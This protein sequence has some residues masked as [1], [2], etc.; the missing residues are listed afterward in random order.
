MPAVQGK[1][2]GSGSGSGS[3]AQDHAGGGGAQGHAEGGGGGRSSAEGRMLEGLLRESLGVVN[4]QVTLLSREE[5][6]HLL[7]NFD[8]GKVES[9]QKRKG[10]YERLLRALKEEAEGDDGEGGG[11]IINAELKSRIM[12]QV[13]SFSHASRGLRVPGGVL[14][15]AKQASE[16][17]SSSSSSLSSSLS[18]REFL[19]GRKKRLRNMVAD[20]REA[21][22]AFLAGGGENQ[23]VEAEGSAEGQEKGKEGGTSY[24]GSSHP[25][26][27]MS[28]PIE[29]QREAYV[30]LKGL[31]LLELQKK[32]RQDVLMEKRL[33]EGMDRAGGKST[34]GPGR[35]NFN[36]LTLFDHSRLSRVRQD[37]GSLSMEERRGQILN[38]NLAAEA[39]AK[40]QV[41]RMQKAE[42]RAH[43]QAVHQ[44]RIAEQQR[45]AAEQR[46]RRQEAYERARTEHE[47]KLRVLQSRKRFLQDV[48]AQREDRKAKAKA[49]RKLLKQRSEQTIS[50]HSKERKKKIREANAR[51][52]ALRT[53]NMEEYI[54]MAK[55]AKNSRISMLLDNTDVLLQNLGVKVADQ[56]AA[57]MGQFEDTDGQ[58]LLRADD[59]VQTSQQEDADAVEQNLISGQK[60]YLNL[61]HSKQEPVDEQPVMLEGGQLREYQLAG[62]QWMVSLYINGLNGIL[63]DEMG[64]GKTIQTISLF[65]YLMEKKGN[66]GPHLVLCP[67]AVLSN[68]CVEFG[69]W[70]PNYNVILYDGK[71][72]ERKQLRDDRMAAQTFNVLL[73]HYDMI[74]RD[75]KFLT[76]FQWEYIII[77]EGHRLKNKDSKLSEI[78]RGVYQSRNRL[79]L[80]G[81][82]IQN[83]LKELWSLLNF[84]LPKV[85]DTS[86]SFDDWFSAPFKGSQEDV[87]L[88]EEEELLIIHRLHQVIRPFLLRRKKAEVEKEL[89]DKSIVICKCDLSAWQRAYYK[90]ITEGGSVMLETPKG[91][92]KSRTLMN[93]A[94]QLRKACI[95]PYLF[96][97][98]MYPPYEPED[99][100]ELVRASGKFHLLDRVLPKLKAAG[101]RVLLFSQMTRAMDLLELY[102]EMQGYR[103]LRLDGETKTHERP[104]LLAEFNAPGSDVFLFMLSTRAGG[105]GL[106]LQTADTVI[107][108]DS[109]WNP[110]M[111][112]QA[113]DRAHRIGQKR[114]VKIIT[115]VT[116]GSIEEVIIER[117]REKADIDNK[118]IQAGMFNQSSSHR[119]R[120]ETLSNIF[121]R[122]IQDIG[123]GVSTDDEINNLIARGDDEVELFAKMDLEREKVGL[124]DDTEVPQWALKPPEEEKDEEKEEELGPRRAKSR[125]VVYDD[126]LT[127][128]MWQKLID[129]GEDVQEA[130]EKRQERKRGR[131]KR[132]G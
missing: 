45:I 4:E 87:A 125:K 60:R 91:N 121:K 74:M 13:R 22:E 82:P 59:A 81:T 129:E 85:F 112:K 26:K 17:T 54:K 102:F 104:L 16:P 108:F 94:M 80:T 8:K 53:D 124:L 97:D 115:F 3:A 46:R 122:G 90:Q 37:I 49:L 9:W 58:H 103:Y 56:R 40:L 7:S 105:L 23:E 130:I 48:M 29:K 25:V 96:L 109:D 89:P 120:H 11:E 73:T 84:V 93:S 95:H 61:V 128:R 72:E 106:N 78:L 52:L 6:K 19:R 113:E 77:D 28:T 66:Y 10:T 110:Q 118:V 35:E 34:G 18:G 75:K 131:A 67:K 27:A 88:S 119:E 15:R 71:P 5:Q 41:N 2:S 30:A 117:A 116:V 101:H 114:E 51:V 42:E 50:F 86:D 127:D 31:K 111:D 62:L 43:A 99:P 38:A 107:L 57:T 65:A 55:E 79:L 100:A 33:T 83:N 70:L 92:S 132:L 63:A 64:L 44:A 47:A 126:G 68:W 14:A 1:A 39:A 123:K 12:A 76:K 20:R 21:L 36:A 24:L 32:V 98:S 69:R